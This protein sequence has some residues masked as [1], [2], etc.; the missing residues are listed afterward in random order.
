VIGHVEYRRDRS[1]ADV[2]DR[3]SEQQTVSASLVAS[4]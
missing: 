1:T 4:F 3:G 2:F